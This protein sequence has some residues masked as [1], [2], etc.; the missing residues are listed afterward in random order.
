MITVKFC[1]M[2]FTCEQAIKGFDYIHLVDADGNLT[3]CFEGVTD[4]SQFSI[5]GGTW[6]VA[7]YSEDCNLA[8]VGADGVIRSSARKASDIPV[9]RKLLWSGSKTVGESINVPGAEDYSVFAIAVDTGG[10]NLQV[11]TAMRGA[12]SSLI[13]GSA[14]WIVTTPLGGTEYCASTQYYCIFEITGDSWY[15]A[16]SNELVTGIFGIDKSVPDKVAYSF[17]T[18]NIEAIY[19][20]V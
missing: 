5:S 16:A 6:T 4:F 8:V 2:T 13:E 9:R 17:N 3:A 1:N 15:I 14:S 19:G 18:L 20:I 7:P 11:V 10:T 12:L